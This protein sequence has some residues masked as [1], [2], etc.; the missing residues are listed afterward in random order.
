MKRDRQREYDRMNLTVAKAILERP[1]R[2]G[3]LD[4]LPVVCS[5]Q[6]LRRLAGSEPR[7]QVAPDDPPRRIFRHGKGGYAE[8]AG[9]GKN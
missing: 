4:S 5:V 8:C 7:H 3:G 6:T 2:Y 9:T 1:D